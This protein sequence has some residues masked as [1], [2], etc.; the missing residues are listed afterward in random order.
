METIF[1]QERDPILGII[2]AGQSA[3]DGENCLLLLRRQYRHIL[4]ADPGSEQHQLLTQSS[5]ADLPSQ[6]QR[7]RNHLGCT[8]VAILDKTVH[9]R[10]G[11]LLLASTDQS[12]QIFPGIGRLVLLLAAVALQILQICP[13]V[14]RRS[15][16]GKRF[17]ITILESGIPNPFVQVCAIDVANQ[18]PLI[19]R[20]INIQQKFRRSGIVR[21]IFQ[22]RKRP[23]IVKKHA[24]ANAKGVSVA[25]IGEGLGDALLETLD[26]IFGIAHGSQQIRVADILEHLG[27]FRLHDRFLECIDRKTHND[28]LNVVS[29]FGKIILTAVLQDRLCQVTVKSQAAGMEQRLLDQRLI[30]LQAKQAPQID[31]DIGVRPLQHGI[32]LKVPQRI[33]IPFFGV[34]QRIKLLGCPVEV[35][36]ALLIQVLF[37]IPVQVF[38][39]IAE[40][41]DHQEAVCSGRSITGIE[42]F[43]QHPNHFCRI[44][45]G[46]HRFFIIQQPQH[47]FGIVTDQSCREGADGAQGP[48]SFPLINLRPGCILEFCQQHALM[49][50]FRMIHQQ[51]RKSRMLLEFRQR[52]RITRS[53]C[54]RIR[55][56]R[57][58]LRHPAHTAVIAHIAVHRKQHLLRHRRQRHRPQQTFGGTIFVFLNLIKPPCLGRN[59]RA[60]G[61]SLCQCLMDRLKFA[62]AISQFQHL[63]GVC[64]MLIHRICIII[65]HRF[66]QGIELEFTHTHP[67]LIRNAFLTGFKHCCKNIFAEGPDR[68]DSRIQRNEFLD[69]LTGNHLIGT[70]DRQS[71]AG[72]FCC[73]VQFTIRRIPDGQK[74]FLIICFPIQLQQQ[75]NTR[76]PIRDQAQQQIA[77]C[78]TFAIA[79]TVQNS[80]R[81]AAWREVIKD[82]CA[83]L[84]FTFRQSKDRTADL[85][86][87]CDQRAVSL[88]PVMAERRLRTQNLRGK[89]IGIQGFHLLISLNLRGPQ[90]IIQDPLDFV[91][92][93]QI[94]VC[95]IV[96]TRQDSRHQQLAQR[97]V[98][99]NNA[100]FLKDIISVLRAEHTLQAGIRLQDLLKNPDIAGRFVLGKQIVDRFHIRRRDHSAQCAKMLRGA[101]MYLV[102]YRKCIPCYIKDPIFLLQQ[103]PELRQLQFAFVYRKRQLV[104][105]FSQFLPPAFIFGNICGNRN[106]AYAAFQRP[107]QIFNPGQQ[108][109]S[110]SFQRFD[111]RLNVLVGNTGLVEE[112]PFKPYTKT[113]RILLTGICR[114]NKH[115]LRLLLFIRI[116][117]K[118]TVNILTVVRSIAA[119]KDHPPRIVVDC[120]Q[121]QPLAINQRL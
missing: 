83:S 101:F 47:F 11:S 37:H 117:L 12:A 107:D 25:A 6:L 13:A 58:S 29:K 24:H 105:V 96:L 104:Q 34:S 51:L 15:G 76:S 68:F 73:V 63:F 35:D 85:L 75:F 80:G 28:P 17:D 4:Q 21:C 86:V 18:I 55:C 65:D 116:R 103:R 46:F 48:G 1:L 40:S 74:T 42:F 23:L 30:P 84:S 45:V 106:R 79:A 9:F 5:A 112:P 3:I 31:A 54:G 69:F 82:F 119:G 50:E 92:G 72:I 16:L 19:F 120:I 115:P 64:Q 52:Q 43:P 49:P 87:F 97:K 78:Q 33:Q 91:D 32:A 95:L 44:A 93:L 70:T 98:F 38:L 77:L 61:K 7:F 10:Q 27:I 26:F 118:D 20:E 56:N 67:S 8:F 53:H 59:V 41:L 94:G 71:V 2:T 66:F 39:I 100:D 111:L 60:V 114:A 113:R 88:Q 110:Q 108:A 89:R 99:G 102:K 57:K 22:E 90:T 109:G 81:N 36:I 62:F 121:Q 14:F